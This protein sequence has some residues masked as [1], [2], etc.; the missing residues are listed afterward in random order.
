MVLLPSIQK[1]FADK[2]ETAALCVLCHNYVIVSRGAMDKRECCGFVLYN[3]A[4]VFAIRIKRKV[5][6]LRIAPIDRGTI[7]VLR[8]RAAVTDYV[9]AIVGVV[10]SPVHK[11][12]TIH[13][14]RTNRSGSRAVVCCDLRRRSPAA[15]PAY[16][17]RLA[18]PKVIDLSEKQSRP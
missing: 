14:E 10:E 13:S 12:T 1:R 8:C 9:F 11:P 7:A 18:A 6:R 15:V 3:Y 17:K 4:D 5:S 16:N 2:A